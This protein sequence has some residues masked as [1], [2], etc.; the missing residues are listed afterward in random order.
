MIQEFT[1]S[2][3]VAYQNWG[4][5]K[6]LLGIKIY[7]MQASDTNQSNPIIQGCQDEC[8]VAFTRQMT[9]TTTMTCLDV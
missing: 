8:Y 9:T 7:E 6:T 4:F 5:W 1:R 2:D 3:E